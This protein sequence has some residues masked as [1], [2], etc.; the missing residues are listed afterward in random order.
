MTGLIRAEW[1]LAYISQVIPC[2]WSQHVYTHVYNNYSPLRFLVADAR[3]LIAQKAVKEEYEWLFF[4]D[5]DVVL[6]HDTFSKFNRRISDN[7]IPMFAG[8]YFT[9]SLPAEPLVYRGR[10]NSFFKD[11]KLGEEVWVDG[12]GLGCNAI[13]VSILKYLY[14]N[15]EE[16]RIKIDE[17]GN[18]TTARKIFDTPF[19][20]WDSNGG[21]YKFSGTEDLPFYER[22]IKEN[23]FEKTGWTSDVINKEYPFLCDTSIFCMHIDQSGRKYPM[24]NEQNE[25]KA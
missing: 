10:G 2:N 6:P 19:Q 5:H 12:M 16:Y 18:F 13:N 23:V 21:F 22:I 20:S 25:F 1:H 15:S 17:K 4:I 9:K 24:A 8:L 14:D 3:N 7:N 11:W